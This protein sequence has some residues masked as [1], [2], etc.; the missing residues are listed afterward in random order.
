[1]K[2][3]LFI[4]FGCTV[5]LAGC[6][7]GSPL[8][9]PNKEE[10]LTDIIFGKEKHVIFQGEKAN[11]DHQQY[12]E[13]ISIVHDGKAKVYNIDKSDKELLLSDAGNMSIKEL[14]KFGEQANKDAGYPPAYYTQAKVTLLTDDEQSVSY[15]L[16]G[17][18]DFESV[19]GRYRDYY[20]KTR[21]ELEPK[22]ERLVGEPKL[23]KE[24]GEKVYY[25]KGIADM[26]AHDLFERTL[27]NQEVD[28][29]M[30]STMYRG[31]M[32]DT[33]MTTKKDQVI[34]GQQHSMDNDMER[35]TNFIGV[36]VDKNTTITKESID[37][38]KYTHNKFV[39]YVEY[40]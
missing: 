25:F 7:S 1:M 22:M 27:K 33:L 4:L 5:I 16:R 37:S 19:D 29:P 40:N 3:L 35:D 13:R 2:K 11:D 15:D 31:S 12:V 23:S 10:T 28:R 39:D 24:N 9:K 17:Y 30:I 32:N 21:Q 26:Q 18:D 14:E 38:G 20:G 36:R 34:K 6:G 8:A